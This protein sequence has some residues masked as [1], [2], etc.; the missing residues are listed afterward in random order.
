MRNMPPLMIKVN[1]VSG[2]KPNYYKPITT[3]YTLHSC[4]RPIT[5]GFRFSKHFAP[6]CS[7]KP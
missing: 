2:T 7:F 5:I 6:F 1:K 3:F 4:L